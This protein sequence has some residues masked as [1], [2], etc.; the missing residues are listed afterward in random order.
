M[1]STILTFCGLL[2]AALWL[3]LLELTAFNVLI[4]CLGLLVM[5]AITPQTRGAKRW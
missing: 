1:R 4:V 2:S 5:L 3:L